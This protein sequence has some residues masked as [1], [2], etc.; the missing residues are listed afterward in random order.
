[1][2]NKGKER[3]THNQQVQQKGIEMK[4]GKSKNTM[5][6]LAE[7]MAKGF[8]E[9]Q[10]REDISDWNDLLEL[11]SEGEKDHNYFGARNVILEIHLNI[12]LALNFEIFYSI[13]KGIR[14][15]TKR[16]QELLSYVQDIPYIK[17]I[18]LI[19]LLGV[20]AK[21]NISFVYAINDLRNDLA[22]IKEPKT[23][24]KFEGE[25]ITRKETVVKIIK[26]YIA[27]KRQYVE[28]ERRRAPDAL[29]G[30]R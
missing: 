23:G 17:K 11:C 14:Y 2:T 30:V 27:F 10:K 1:M 24:L 25:L 6:N 29:K 12:E 9:R 22:H 19:D 26:K 18:K 8:Q 7:L 20:F 13:I 5:P 21:K 15:G 28:I 4:K 3:L 16:V